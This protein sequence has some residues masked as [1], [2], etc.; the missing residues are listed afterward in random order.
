MEVEWLQLTSYPAFRIG[1]SATLRSISR[2]RVAHLSHVDAVRWLWI[3]M[4]T[5]LFTSEPRG[6]AVWLKFCFVVLFRQVWQLAFLALFSYVLLFDLSDTPTRCYY[7]LGVWVADTT[8]EEIR[9]VKPHQLSLAGEWKPRS[10]MTPGKTCFYFNALHC[11][12]PLVGNIRVTVP[13]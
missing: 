3:T 9:Q 13:E 5:M 11:C 6:H 10:S 4:G 7:A 12:N 1:P 2:E 8:A